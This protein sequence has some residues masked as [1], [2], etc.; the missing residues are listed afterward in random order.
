M[1]YEV[2]KDRFEELMLDS[3]RRVLSDM[4]LTELHESATYLENYAWEYSKLNAMSFVAYATGDDDWQHEICASLD[5]L[6]GGEKDE[7]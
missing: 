1:S 5:Q 7:H 6:K 4:E 3:E 2:V